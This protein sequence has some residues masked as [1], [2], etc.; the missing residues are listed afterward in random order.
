MTTTG[1]IAG[2]R[3]ANVTLSSLGESNIRNVERENSSREF[4]CE[5]SCRGMV[6]NTL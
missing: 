1:F 3:D 5:M 4:D 6:V 2:L